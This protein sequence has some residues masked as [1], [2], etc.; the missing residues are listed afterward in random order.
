MQSTYAQLT[1]LKTML[2]IKLAC[3]ISASSFNSHPSTSFP[4]WYVQLRP[5]HRHPQDAYI[6]SI[7]YIEIGAFHRAFPMTRRVKS[8]NPNPKT[9][10]E[11]LDYSVLWFAVKTIYDLRISCVPM[12][13]KLVVFQ[14][15]DMI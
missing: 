3:E 9:R 7:P 13:A 4:F 15:P 10:I 1:V 14:T 8:R 6:S 5:C 12:P 2:L 11:A